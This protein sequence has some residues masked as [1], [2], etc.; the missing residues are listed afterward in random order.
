MKTRLLFSKAN[1]TGIAMLSM[2]LFSACQQEMEPFADNTAHNEILKDA[3]LIHNEM[4]S[5]YYM[6]RKIEA[7]PLEQMIPELLKLSGE[8]LDQNGYDPAQ[9]KEAIRQVREKLGSS[10]LKSSSANCFSIDKSSFH[11]QIFVTHLYSDYFIDE[12]AKVL[13]LAE[14]ND[15]SRQVKEYVN[16]TFSTI[17]FTQENDLTGQQLFTNIFNGSYEFW[18]TYEGSNLK[19]KS[20][21]KNTWVIVNDGIGGVLG[22]I[23]GPIGSIV[24]A[25]LFSAATNEELNR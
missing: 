6:N 15:D 12:V 8:Y 20:W 5:Y 16:S 1:L 19:A 25:T 11:T 7:A 18:E 22:S 24:T 2:F 9:T 14:E 21:N 23:F 3:G 10:P 17:R 13:A 4:I